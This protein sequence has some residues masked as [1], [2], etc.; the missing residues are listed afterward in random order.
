MTPTPFLTAPLDIQ[1]HIIAACLALA[2]GPIVLYRRRRDKWHRIL[3]Y[4]WIVAMASL[5]ISSFAIPSHFTALGLGPLHGFAVVTLWSLWAGVRAARVRD[6]ERHQA[7]FRSLYSNGLIIAGAFTFV[8]GR[9]FSRIVFGEASQL[10]W[11]IIA[12]VLALVAL[13]LILPRLRPQ[14]RA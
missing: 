11:G 13:R 1:V 12:A 8:P 2:L 4:A 10:G 14:I 9:T 7:I 5:A 3:G 6:V